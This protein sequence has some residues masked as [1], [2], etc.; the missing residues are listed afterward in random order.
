MQAWQ[1]VLKT[2]QF[3][4]LPVKLLLQKLQLQLD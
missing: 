3:S 2:T 4:D 1:L